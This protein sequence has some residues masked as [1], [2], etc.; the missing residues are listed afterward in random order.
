MVIET[1]AAS[2]FDAALLCI[3]Q[4][5]SLE[6]SS[7]PPFGLMDSNGFSGEFGLGTA[8]MLHHAAETDSCI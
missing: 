8:Q 2:I 7:P 5:L 1:S 6:A 4:G 3:T